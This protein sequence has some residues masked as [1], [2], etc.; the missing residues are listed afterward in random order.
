M[1]H[2]TLPPQE[3]GSP[4][5]RLLR[6]ATYASVGVAL[7]LITIKAAAW[8][9]TNSIGLQASL[10]D[11]VLDCA[12]SLINLVAVREA[13][14][15]ADREHRFGH[16]KIEAVAALAQ[17]MFIAGS[18]AWLIF[19]SAE[20]LAHPHDLE[21]TRAGI[22]VMTISMVLTLGLV[23]FQNHVI[24]KTQSTAIKADAIHYRSDF[25]INGSVIVS[26]GLA[27]WLHL[28]LLDPLVG[29]G[30]ALYILYTAWTISKEAF[31]VLI[32]RELAD[33]DRERI[34][35]IALTHKDVT[36]LHDLRTRSSGP[37]KFIQLHL[38]MDG[39]MS[40]SAAHV[41]ADDVAVLIADAFPSAEVIIH[42]DPYQLV[43][44]KGINRRQPT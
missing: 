36:G 30:I 13:L 17:S 2:H 28:P 32:D 33:E 14:K 6:N 3:E 39:N 43:G 24:K 34:T 31:D 7:I 27:S 40:L 29:A 5:A 44:K 22:L 42:Q 1:D 37:H 20:R 18:A 41:I 4:H 35:Q 15:P 16:G 11:S 23:L 25:L 9:M 21:H 8:I 38:E 12:A 26:L 19:E 10:V